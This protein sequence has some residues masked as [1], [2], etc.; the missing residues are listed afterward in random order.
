V[1]S[2]NQKS[3]LVISGLGIGNVLLAEPM[4]RQLKKGLPDAELFLVTGSPETGEILNRSVPFAGSWHLPLRKIQTRTFRPRDMI[5]FV[6]TLFELRA[7]KVDVSITTVPSNRAVWN[8]MA[9]I[10]G[11]RLRITHDYP[12]KRPVALPFLQNCRVPI[13]QE[14]HDIQQNLRLLEPL[15]IPMGPGK[16]RMRLILTR[17]ESDH[18]ASYLSRQGLDDPRHVLVAFHI[19]CDPNAPR[20]WPVACYAQLIERLSLNE[21]LR[22]LVIAGPGEMEL[23]RE[24]AQKTGHIA[25]GPVLVSPPTLFH[26]GAILSRCHLLISNDSGMMHTATAVGTRVLAL[27][28]PSDNNRMAPYQDQ[29]NVVSADVACRPCTTTLKNLGERFS[30]SQ[31]SQYCW[32]GLGVDMVYQRALD[33]IDAIGVR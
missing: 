5:D 3:V 27:F 21:E 33:F 8:V 17:E 32:E 16:E 19:G 28:G 15:G 14:T 6:S 12:N 18:A 9:L 31:P 7:L 11:A 1:K 25:H 24:L 10:V 20:R 26:S 23:S 4:V 29:K 22:F 2:Q 30:C 13:L